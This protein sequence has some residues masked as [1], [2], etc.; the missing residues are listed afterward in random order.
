[1]R[2][3]RFNLDK[4]NEESSYIML[5]FSCV[6]KRLRYSTRLECNPQKWDKKQ[7]RVKGKTA[8]DRT[9]NRELEYINKVADS[10]LLDFNRKSK[11][12]TAQEL[13]D[14]LDVELGR[15]EL[16]KREKFQAL[17]YT[18][19]HYKNDNRDHV[20]ATSRFLVEYTKSKY[21][22]LRFEDVDYLYLK[23]FHE[24][25]LENT[26]ARSNNTIATYLSVIKASMNQA[27]KEG[28]HNSQH[29]KTYNVSIP[30]TDAVYLNEVELEAIANV[31]LDSERANHVRDI[32]LIG[33]YTGLRVSDYTNIRLSNVK[34]IEGINMLHIKQ[35]KTKH[36]VY[37][38]MR[39]IVMKLLEK[40]DYTVPA[41]GTRSIN[42][43]I[44]EICKKAGITSEV[45]LLTGNG[46]VKG[47]KYTFIS[48]HTARRSFATNAFLAGV[49]A[50]AIMKITG[51]QTQNSFMR[52]ICADNLTNAIHIADH[53]FFK[54]FRERAKNIVPIRKVS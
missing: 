47:E 21:N 49:P 24:W 10:I 43:N 11:P 54:D 12:V 46:V 20:K 33:A 44:K 51:H 1:M 38:P 27:Y 42:L 32:F 26:N 28:L 45:E 14:R 22:S 17:K 9:V 35:K 2:K 4:K 25:L 3:V 50:L 48:S 18:L 7:M 52:Y 16:D 29:Y 5:V 31:E 53:G 40:Y 39:T 23:G 30:K 15:K 19:N 8:H 6:D 37:I 36:D 41:I 13:R 34:S